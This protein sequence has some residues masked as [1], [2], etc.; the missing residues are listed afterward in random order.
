LR[1]YIIWDII[2]Q[3]G[4]IHSTGF[5]L[6]ILMI[7][8]KQLELLQVVFTVSNVHRDDFNGQILSKLYEG[9]IKCVSLYLAQA[10]WE[11]ILVG[12]W[13]KRAWMLP[14]LLAGGICKP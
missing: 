6:F 1:P 9:K 14:L 12:D 5:A 11:D 7:Y 13:H 8:V 3:K 2:F 4:Q 10:L